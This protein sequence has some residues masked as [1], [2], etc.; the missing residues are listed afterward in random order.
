[1][2]RVSGLS[3]FSA[4]L[5]ALTLGGA[6]A[7]TPGFVLKS[8]QFPV[9][10]VTVKANTGAPV[11]EQAA[12]SVLAQQIA[13][14][15]GVTLGKARV[16]RLTSND[17][18]VK[19]PQL[20]KGLAVA[21][22]GAAVTFRGDVARL[23][24]SRLESDLP[25]DVTP[26]L[27][28][29]QAAAI[30]EGRTG[31][32]VAPDQI[33]LVLWPTPDGVRLVWAMSGTP[34]FGVPYQPVTVVDA[35]T[36]DIVHIYN[37]IVHLNQSKVF[38]S[39]P[40]KSPALA[41][42]ALAVQEGK[43]V[44]ENELVQSLNCIDKKSVKQ[45][46][47]MGF[48]LDVHT[49]DLLQTAA[50]DAAGDYLIAPGENE[51]PEDAF[52]E[53]SMFYHVNRAYEMFRGW[54]ATLDVNDGA[55][56]PT[57]S[58][59][60]IPQGFSNFDLDKIKDPELPLAP[61]QNAFY[62][63]ANPLFSSVFGING[64]AMWFGQGPIND[65]SYDGDVVYHELTHAVVDSTL[66]L[67]G[68]PHM[69]EFGTSYSPGGMNEGLADYFSSALTGDGDVGEYAS[70]DFFPGS[71][72]IRSLTNGD[73]CP[74]AIGGE[75]HQDATL[76]SGALWDVRTN[77]PEGEQLKLD[78][79]VF[80]AMNASPTGDL[81]YE[82]L[83]ELISVQVKS[84]VGDS[85]AQAL[86]AAFTAR[87]VLP[88][89]TR[90]LDYKGT[91]L[92]GPKDLKNLWFAPGTQTTGAKNQDGKWT[93]GVVQV[94]FQLPAG[95]TKLM[96]QIREVQVGGGGI[97][98]GGGTPFT[99]K[100]LVRFSKD[101]ITFTYKPTKT[102][103]DVLVLDGVAATNKHTLEVDVPAGSTD[104]YVMV[105]NTGESDGAYTDFTMEASFEP[106]ATG[107]GGAGGGGSGGGGITPDATGTGAAGGSDTVVQGGCGC[108]L[109]GER[110]P[111]GAA[112]A[113][114]AALGLLASRRRRR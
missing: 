92:T 36:G 51:E 65:Y 97:G 55:P 75:V 31:L 27:T 77:L 37:A 109:P 78:A 11:L 29:D 43:T 2:R 76:F 21:H 13:A 9:S 56:I 22:R 19:L 104:V 94:H 6:A 24:S 73:T 99:P 111:E 102:T 107:S 69:D 10:D 106:I 88:Q 110:A 114:L 3:S 12:R 41:D 15:R 18:I 14:S 58:N 82:D 108:A 74:T 113:A 101:P 50:P 85:A 40:V 35:K 54:D 4:A 39:N 62:S 44:L 26:Q 23:V 72:A 63:P 98:G 95:A 49:C 38:P 89:C 80:A 1:M 112:F 91:K 71:T 84:L 20:H 7:A 105:G 52:S 16:V 28:S 64:G 68:T 59:L 48:M 17:R 42:V 8:G 25:D 45:V 33:A 83:A 86:T 30:A 34:V 87:G 93:P 79:A 5:V 103:D 46:S 90:I 47:L 81:A 66:K 60:R 53:V 61:F 70:Q 96:A 67:V 57:V 100:F 32:P